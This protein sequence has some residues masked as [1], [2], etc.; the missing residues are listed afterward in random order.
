M[1]YGVLLDDTW[2]QGGVLKSCVVA[3]LVLG[4]LPFIVLATS[5]LLSNRP[6][7]L[8]IP[9]YRSLPGLF[10]DQRVS[11]KDRLGG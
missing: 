2:D 3:V 8:V 10:D 7:W 5:V 1:V 4:S 6:S 9:A 11:K